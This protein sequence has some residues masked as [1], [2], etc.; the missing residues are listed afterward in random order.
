MAE[1]V[2]ASVGSLTVL[3]WE[4]EGECKSYTLV[5]CFFTTNVHFV[6]VLGAPVD[7]SGR[8]SWNEDCISHEHQRLVEASENEKEASERPT[9]PSLIQFF[10]FF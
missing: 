8:V 3:E 7:K 2:A 5:L 10:I 9:Q 6:L 1:Y 4:G